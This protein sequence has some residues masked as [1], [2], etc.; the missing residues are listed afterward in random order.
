MLFVKLGKLEFQ[1]FDQPA[2]RMSLAVLRDLDRL[3]IYRG[4]V[5]KLKNPVAQ[6]GG[7]VVDVDPLEPRRSR[8][9]VVFLWPPVVDLV[10]V[11]P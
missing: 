1:H 9:R 4:P 11:D 7:M 10:A 6:G 2:Q 5:Q 8:E 3:P